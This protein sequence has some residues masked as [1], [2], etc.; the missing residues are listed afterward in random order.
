[1]RL[2]VAQAKGPKRVRGRGKVA[3]GT[4]A[5]RTTFREHGTY[6]QVAALPVRRSADGNWQVL[7]VTSR[8]TRRWVIPK[9][10]PMKKL[11]DHKAAALE[12]EQEAGVVGRVSKEPVGSYL[13]WKRRRAHFDLCRVDV[14]LLDV[15][16]QLARWK[17]K[18]Q[19]TVRWL[20]PAIAACAVHEPGLTAL[21][22]QLGS[23]D[24]TRE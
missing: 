2:G 6:R 15:E 3:S 11:K 16:T 18:A 12:A 5:A 1:V 21:I 19:R 8:E 10:W 17:E 13:Y 4:S 9:G 7:L 24:A 23:V 14:Y 20:E 22:E